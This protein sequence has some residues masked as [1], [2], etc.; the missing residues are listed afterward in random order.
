MGEGLQEPTHA[1]TIDTPFFLPMMHQPRAQAH[2]LGKLSPE[3][4]PLGCICCRFFSLS[5]DRKEHII[6]EHFR[7][8]YWQDINQS[9]S[10]FCN[11]ISPE[12]LF[13]EVQMYPRFLL[14]GRWSRRNRENRFVYYLSFPFD[15]GFVPGPNCTT[16]RV[17]IVCACVHCPACG[18]H[19]PTKI[20]TMYP[21]RVAN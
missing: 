18:V 11:S 7:P 20:I 17:E 16:N 5:E 12:E 21:V 1:N 19:P 13:H 9:K 8:R 14:R 6:Q 4:E 15:V 3:M 2:V 10:S